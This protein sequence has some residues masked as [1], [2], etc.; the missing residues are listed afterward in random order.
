M[1]AICLYFFRANMVTPFYNPPLNFHFRVDFESLKFINPIGFG[2]QSVTGIEAKM[3]IAEIKE[4][5]EN[6][7]VHRLPGRMNY[8]NLVLKRGL[9]LLDLHSPLV[10]WCMD[11]LQGG[12]NKTIKPINVTVSLLNELMIPVATWQF[13]RAYP[14]RWVIG[15]LDTESEGI[16]LEEIELC[17][18][19]SYRVDGGLL[20]ML[21]KAVNTIDAGLDI[22][23]GMSNTVGKI[24]DRIENS[25]K[26]DADVDAAKAKAVSAEADTKKA[27]AKKAEA[28][29]AA[30]ANKDKAA[31]KEK[32][33]AD[34][35]KQD[36]AKADAKKAEEAAKPAAKAK[37][38]AAAATAKAK[39]EAAE[40]KKAKEL[41][42]NKAKLEERKKKVKEIKTKTEKEAKPTKTEAELKAEAEKKAAEKKAAAEAKKAAAQAKAAEREAAKAA[43]QAR[44][45]EERKR[46][47][48]ERKKKSDSDKPK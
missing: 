46:K 48:A 5:G 36:K 32:T 17:Y 10:N 39:L 8:E 30:A 35:A 9:E 42:E 3:D 43:E 29:K 44:L 33:K 14:V 11:T 20:G 25:T 23:K 40:A 28:D 21:G 1:P 38:E 19:Y 41:A 31:T 18:S 16:L 45:A 7:F 2:F 34:D 24:G 15:D 22:V 12:L 26:D 37:K 27:A 47:A 6:L 4:G 13:K